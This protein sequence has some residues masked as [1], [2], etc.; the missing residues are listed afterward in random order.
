MGHPRQARDIAAL[1][2]ASIATLIN[3]SRFRVI[4]LD[5]D[6][7][8]AGSDGRVTPRSITALTRAQAVGLTVVIVTA[9][10]YPTAFALWRDA[11]LSAPLI[12]CGGALTLQPPSLE[13][14]DAHALPSRVV[15]EAL[16]L[17]RDLDLV[18]TLWST[19]MIWTTESGPIADRTQAI[20]QIAVELLVPGQQARLEDGSVSILKLMVGGDPERIDHVRAEVRARLSSAE[21][22]R[23]MA[24]FLDVTP[25][26]ASKAR[27][28]QAVLERLG[29]SAAET[30]AVGDGDNDV[31]MLT[32]A[33]LAVA[34]A[35]AMPGPRAVADLVVGRNDQDGVATFLEAVVSVYASSI[36]VGA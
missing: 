34:P 25:T 14:L 32:L 4:A 26:E 33:G 10:A 16:L 3:W 19:D 30:I 5:L 21:V 31:G 23:S 27:A 35:N 15:A 28:L 6:G 13:V 22:A 18:V 7:T 9:R 36:Q 12:T 24:G 8:L 17:G 1:D 20:N 2:M 29:V 11:G